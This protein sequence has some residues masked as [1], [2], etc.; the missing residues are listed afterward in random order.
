MGMGTDPPT[1]R[2][3]S[4]IARR[5]VGQAATARR[6]AGPGLRSVFRPIGGKGATVN[7]AG[8][9]TVREGINGFGRTG[10]RTR[11]AYD[12]AIVR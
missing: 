6:G 1:S 12:S 4:R 11:S 7:D 3:P 2:H 10:R 8:V 5:K 9:M